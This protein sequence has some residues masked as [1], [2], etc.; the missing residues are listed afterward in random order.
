MKNLT[1]GNIYK[2]FILFAIPMVLAALLSQAY[3]TIDTIIAGKFLGESGIAAVGATSAFITFVSSIFWG[4]GTGLS[5]YVAKLFGALEYRKLRDDIYSNVILLV[6][7]E[8][9]VSGLILLL[10]K[11]IYE[12]L[13]V[14]IALLS[15][16]EFVCIKNHPHIKRLFVI[17]VKNVMCFIKVINRHAAVFAKS[18]K[19]I[20][21]NSADVRKL[22]GFV[23]ICS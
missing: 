20:I 3:N 17:I 6:A 12:L 23:N 1:S 16:P 9:V 2:N 7:V 21:H 15:E 11:Q 13:K 18:Y 4:F 22:N 8:V 14:S 19:V 10:R 5:V